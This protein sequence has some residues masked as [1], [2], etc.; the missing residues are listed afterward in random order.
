MTGV[1]PGQGEWIIVCGFFETAS[2]FSTVVGSIL[3][4]ERTSGEED[5]SGRRKDQEFLSDTNE[6]KNI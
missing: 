4:G 3:E 6:G 5:V 2:R 1:V